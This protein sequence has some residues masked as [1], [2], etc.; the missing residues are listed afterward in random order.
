MEEVAAKRP[1]EVEAQRRKDGL[2]WLTPDASPITSSVSFADSSSIEEERLPTG[3]RQED[4][5]HLL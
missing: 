3:R 4:H 1:E 2:M 5:T